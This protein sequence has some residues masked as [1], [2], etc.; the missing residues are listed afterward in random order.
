MN[1]RRAMF[2]QGLNASKG[3]CCQIFFFFSPHF[4]DS[5]STLSCHFPAAVGH[6]CSLQSDAETNVRGPLPLLMEVGYCNIS[7]LHHVK[8]FL[9]TP[10]IPHFLIIKDFVSIKDFVHFKYENTMES[11]IL[12]VFL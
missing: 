2:K 11:S 3:K 5:K 6:W 7:L 4:T 10:P 12:I 8:D 9:T 1:E